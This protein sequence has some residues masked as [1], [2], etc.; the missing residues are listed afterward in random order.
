MLTAT[1]LSLSLSLYLSI[2]LSL[3]LSLYIYIYIYIYREYNQWKSCSIDRE[4]E[5]ANVCVIILYIFLGP[6]IL[7]LET[8]RES[9]YYLVDYI[10]TKLEMAANHR[11]Y[12]IY[13]C[14]D[15]ERDL[16]PAG[17]KTNSHYCLLQSLESYI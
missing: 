2:S 14:A 16:I 13:T 7:V 8:T 3:S 15:I 9:I 6:S 11:T 4:R 5:L 12:S 10:I 1:P 17:G